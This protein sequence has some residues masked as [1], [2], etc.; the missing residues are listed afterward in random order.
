MTRILLFMIL[1]ATPAAWA[2]ESSLRHVVRVFT[3]NRADGLELLAQDL[4]DDALFQK[5]QGAAKTAPE[6]LERLIVLSTEETGEFRASQADEFIYPTEFDP[7]QLPQTLAIGSSKLAALL[8]KLLEKE[9]APPQP[10]PQ[11]AEAPKAATAPEKPGARHPVNRGLGLITSITPTAFEMRP[12]GE[13]LDLRIENGTASIS[14]QGARL[15]GLQNY[16]GELKAQ[17]SAREIFTATPVTLGSTVFLGTFTVAQKTGSEFE[18]RAESLSLA[19]LTTR[20]S[21]MPAAAEPQVL[22]KDAVD[23]SARLEVLSL[24]KLDAA[25]LLDAGLD[26]GILYSRLQTATSA[27]AGRL[28]VILSGRARLNE[29]SALAETDEFI[30]GVE[31]DPP[32]VVRE[33]VIADDQLL[34]DLRAGRQVGTGAAPPSASPHNGGFGLMTAAT[35]TNFAMRALGSRLVLTV[36]S[37]E[38][39]LRVTA[40]PEFSRLVTRSTFAGISQPVFGS[41]QLTTTRPARLGI[42]LLLGTVNRAL[43]TGLQESEKEDRLWLAFLILRD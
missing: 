42:P 31:F 40:S 34:E 43:N 7:Q 13:S 37:G 9:P 23:V 2:A 22:R 30:Y 25:A 29:E 21:P 12:L 18:N 28:E 15:A 36:R 39:G 24:P 38:N 20:R 14:L 6:M 1:L 5:L 33:L 32:Q 3:V 35:P 19:F 17:F 8:N 11:A 41:Q 16:N 4:D 27:G 26:D 10:A